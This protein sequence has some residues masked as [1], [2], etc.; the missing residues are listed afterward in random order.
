MG[1][2][3][4]ALR[5]SLDAQLRSVTQN[6]S[7]KATVAQ[8]QATDAKSVADQAQADAKAKADEA[9]RLYLAAQAAKKKS[10]EDFLMAAK[11]ADDAR[12]EA[13]RSRFTANAAILAQADAV[14]AATAAA[15]RASQAERDATQAVAD[16]DLARQ[17]L[18]SE[19]AARTQVEVQLAAQVSSVGQLQQAF[20]TCKS[21]LIVRETPVATQIMG[22]KNSP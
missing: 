18:D 21:Q 10:I 15:S 13:E 5:S 16:R 2:E 20:S 4:S 8:K 22:E 14:Q 9:Q 1:L 7:D 3:A 19:R 17:A 11:R 12:A 6:L